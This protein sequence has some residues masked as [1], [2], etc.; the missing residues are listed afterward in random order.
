M[1]TNG[2]LPNYING[3]WQNSTAKEFADVINPAPCGQN[4]GSPS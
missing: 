4:Y 2:R 3:E 1:R